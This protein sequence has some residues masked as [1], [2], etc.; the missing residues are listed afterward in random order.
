MFW[1]AFGVFALTNLIY[2]CLGS[3][4]VQPWN[5]VEDCD[6]NEMEIKKNGK[7]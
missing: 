3:G 7:S 1:I 5:Q 4:E 2:V 6:Q